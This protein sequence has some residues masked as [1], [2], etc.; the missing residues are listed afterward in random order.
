[1][2]ARINDL[3]G[4]P[5]LL[6]IKQEEKSELQPDPSMFELRNYIAE[7]VALPLGSEF[8]KDK[9]DRMNYFC[10]FGPHGAGKTLA[11]RAL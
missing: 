1:M 10:F 4:E 7:N 2:P 6:R 11:I 9:L 3:L 8:L 5:N